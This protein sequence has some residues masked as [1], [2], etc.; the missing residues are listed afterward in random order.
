MSEKIQIN[1]FENVFRIEHTLQVLH[2][3]RLL[4]CE[5]RRSLIEDSSSNHRFPIPFHF[6]QSTFSISSILLHSTFLSPSISLHQSIFSP[7][8]SIHY[9]SM[10]HIE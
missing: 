6:F 4:T 5:Y 1:Q 2:S 7:N 9:R 10:N 3:R 8:Q